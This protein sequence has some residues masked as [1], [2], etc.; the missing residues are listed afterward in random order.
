MFKIQSIHRKQQQLS[1]TVGTFDKCTYNLI[2][3]IQ[4]VLFKHLS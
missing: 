4:Y 3:Y 2:L 1:T